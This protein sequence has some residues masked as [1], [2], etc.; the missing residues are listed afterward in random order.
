[1]EREW[2]RQR[3]SI[4][5]AVVGL[6]TMLSM[7]AAALLLVAANS[8]NDEDLAFRRI[9]C[10]YDAESGLML[11]MGWLR[12]N[13]AAFIKGNRSEWASGK[14][15]FPSLTLENGSLVTITIEDNSATDPM[16]TT[17]TVVSQAVL[18]GIDSVKCFLTVAA[19]DTDSPP[20]LTLT[21]W[22]LQR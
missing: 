8:R 16:D 22:R 11:G 19:A 20:K 7:A 18:A 1:M 2:P 21:K 14:H 6:T 5:V 15:T 4:L 9:G 10:Q 12:Q 13:G 3:G 17:K